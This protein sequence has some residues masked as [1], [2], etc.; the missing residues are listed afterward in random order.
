[1]SEANDPDRDLDPDLEGD[2]PRLSDVGRDSGGHLDDVDIRDLLRAALEPPK[3]EDDGLPRDVLRGVQQR[4]RARSRGKFFADG[5]STAASPRSTYLVTS[6][7][8]LAL[9]AIVFFVL[10]PWVH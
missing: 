4:I 2:L 5:W 3:R 8:M 1:M 9:I 6:A 7:L 10:I